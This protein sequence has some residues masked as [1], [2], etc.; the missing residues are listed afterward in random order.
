MR[1]FLRTEKAGRATLPRPRAHRSRV[2]KCR[3]TAPYTALEPDIQAAGAEFVNSEAVVRRRDGF[4]QG[5]AGQ[6]GIHAR[7]HQNPA[8][9]A[10]IS[11]DATAGR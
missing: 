3:R 7:I 6:P 5:V 2:L 11:R 4:S 9:A 10:P 8:Q 1:H